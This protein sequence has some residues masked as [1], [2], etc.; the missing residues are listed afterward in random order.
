MAIRHELV[1]NK[2]AVQYHGI[3]VFHTHKEDDYFNSPNDYIFSLDPYGSEEDVGEG[4][5]FDIRQLETYD[6]T[7]NVYQ[8]LLRA[9]DEEL[10]GET[11]IMQRESGIIEY[12]SI[13]ENADEHRCPVCGAYLSSS[14]ENVWGDS[15]LT[16]DGS[17]YEYEC[18]CPQCKAI[19]N[20]VY[21]LTFDGYDVL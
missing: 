19:F 15:G 14:D 2:V 10:L 9:I 21:R 13:N 1:E 18:Q 12:I 16:D 6:A 3:T 5:V 7:V 20:Q 8:N 4:A 11:N 17:S